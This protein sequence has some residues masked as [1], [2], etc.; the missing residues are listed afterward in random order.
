MEPEGPEE[1]VGHEDPEGPEDP[2]EPEGP[3]EPDGPDEPEAPE[4]PEEPDGPDAPATEAEAALE[5][6]RSRLGAL[7]GLPWLACGLPWLACLVKV[8][9]GLAYLPFGA[10]AT[11]APSPA[12]M[13]LHCSLLHTNPEY[14]I[15]NASNHNANTK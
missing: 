6:R 5:A 14:D 4:G 8:S 15:R 11:C 2:E 7:F 1:P 12:I 10:M 3:V 13:M 9:F